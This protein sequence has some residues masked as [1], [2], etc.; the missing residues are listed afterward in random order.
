ML[1][2][3]RPPGEKAIIWFNTGCLPEAGEKKPR[4]ASMAAEGVTS[5]VAVKP[6]EAGV[7]GK[8]TR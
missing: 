6:D 5:N 4:D 2:W 7:A 1:A 3:I 8:L